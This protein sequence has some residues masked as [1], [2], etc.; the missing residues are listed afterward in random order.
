MKSAERAVDALR[1]GSMTVKQL[2]NALFMSRDT[3]RMALDVLLASGYV[4]RKAEHSHKSG[5]P[6]FV[7]SLMA[8]STLYKRAYRLAELV[9]DWDAA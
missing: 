3:V 7:Y 5:R 1:L 6:E 9:G 8:Q 4:Q 2:A